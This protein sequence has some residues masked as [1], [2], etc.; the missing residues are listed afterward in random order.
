MGGRDL[1]YISLAIEMQ[2]ESL[3]KLDTW[4]LVCTVC[5]MILQH[6]HMAGKFDGNLI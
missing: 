4:K 6:Y 2:Q 5:C 3:K 1:Q